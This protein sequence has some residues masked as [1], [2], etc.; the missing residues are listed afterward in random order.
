MKVAVTGATGV[1]GRGAVQALVDAGHQ[2]VAN[3]RNERG[4]MWLRR[5]GADPRSADV[6]DTD[7]LVLLFQDCDAV[8]N[9]ATRIPVGYS[10][11]RPGAWRTNDRLRTR[12]V[13]NVTAAARRAG[14]RRVV[15]ESVSFVYADHG[16]EWVTERSPIDITPV[17][18]PVAVAE[19]HI[20]E[21]ACGQR[22]GVVLRF[23]NVVG[24]DAMTRFQLRS[25]RHGRPIGVGSPEA[26]THVVHTEDIGP[27][28]VAAL[29]APSGVYNVGAD[30]VRKGDLVAAYA[31]AAGVQPTGFLGPV[32]RRIAGARLE[33]LS[34]S[35]RICS[36]H[37]AASSGWSPRRGVFGVEWLDAAATRVTHEVRR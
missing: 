7:S 1:L 35:L 29:H 36:E 12:G 17:T 34:R 18:E 10:A 31:A 21:Y 16:E 9:L 20:Q 5:S 24:D 8:V 33:P 13:D 6:F 26:W 28:V 15:Q 30:P 32:L 14:V 2:V 22:V 11:A 3:A 25:V 27:A 19:S 4:A 37:F 23:G